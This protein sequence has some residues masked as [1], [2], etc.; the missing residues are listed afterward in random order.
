M[1]GRKKGVGRKKMMWIRDP[2][3][4]EA[5]ANELAQYAF[6]YHGVDLLR[7]TK[8]DRDQARASVSAACE[9][10]VDMLLTLYKSGVV[11]R[12]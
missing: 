8:M 4:L 2:K 6:E 7:S 11:P 12:G 5:N 9:W 1:V 3:Q 10:A